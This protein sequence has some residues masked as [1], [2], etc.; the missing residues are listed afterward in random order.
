MPHGPCE[1]R[2]GRAARPPEHTPAVQTPPPPQGVPSGSVWSPTHP[3]AWSHTP[4]P[5]HP[6]AAEQS[7]PAHMSAISRG[8]LQML[9]HAFILHDGWIEQLVSMVFGWH[10]SAWSLHER[11]T[12][13]CTV[14]STARHSPPVH[15]PA[16]QEPALQGVPSGCSGAA[17]HSPVAASHAPAALSHSPGAGHVTLKHASGW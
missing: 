4:P 16:W 11:P 3:M 17:P 1:R 7:M 14:Q 8:G 10:E 9:G 6:L 15:T 5:V 2:R 13:A 12:T